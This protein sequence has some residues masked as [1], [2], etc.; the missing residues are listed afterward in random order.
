MQ[1]YMKCK[2]V[3]KNAEGFTY[4]DSLI[5]ESIEG[6]LS[7]DSLV[8]HTID[9]FMSWISQADAKTSPSFSGLPWEMLG[10]QLYEYLFPPNS[11][12]RKAFENCLEAIQKLRKVDPS[13]TLSIYL[14][15]MNSADSLKKVPWEFLVI[16]NRKERT[17]SSWAREETG[18]LLNRVL[19][20]SRLERIGVE[21][22]Q[23]RILVVGSFS[24][25]QDGRQGE[26]LIKEIRKLHTEE[27]MNIAYLLSSESEGDR[28][29]TYANIERELASFRPHVFVYVGAVKD[30]K[31]GLVEKP[32]SVDSISFHDTNL[33]EI[34]WTEVGAFTNIVST[35]TPSTTF[36]LPL[37]PGQLST[38][39]AFSQED[40]ML[41]DETFPALG[42]FQFDLKVEDQSIFLTSFFR[43]LAE[44]KS[45]GEAGK[46][47][48]QA[49]ANRVEFG[50]AS[51]G[52][53]SFASP[54]YYMHGQEEGALVKGI[55]K[56]E[57][58]G[59]TED[60]QLSE[61]KI[62][63]PNC[64]HHIQEG[65]SRCINISCRHKLLNC[66]VCSE[67]M[68]A[69]NGICANCAYRT[70]EVEL[71]PRTVVRAESSQQTLSPMEN[72]KSVSGAGTLSMPA[73][74]LA[75]LA[76]ESYAKES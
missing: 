27:R 17:G 12:T 65:Q 35:H 54:V 41:L 75:P 73:P 46:E 19:P 3:F 52:S 58:E 42:R 37:L 33:P 55:E 31:L 67:V 5:E 43:A 8:G 13:K 29:P 76:V 18:I 60:V 22:T 20:E 16:P 30:G 44:G 48:R 7:T 59:Q 71:F 36:L 63:C 11:A 9:K 51:W 39:G 45:V 68:S 50:R 47:G 64:G 26:G 49:L 40:W 28:K 14:T 69:T 24:P 15:F 66:P 70:G 34:V 61:K 72:G 57:D 25:K 6:K 4:T 2:I 21:D 53:R 23:L 56:K 1:S 10:L 38:K 74:H 62:S 32:D